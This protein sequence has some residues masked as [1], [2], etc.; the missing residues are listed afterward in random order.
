MENKHNGGD[1]IHT[2]VES[3]HCVLCCELFVLQESINNF[4]HVILTIILYC[5]CGMVCGGGGGMLFLLLFHNQPVL[6]SS[7]KREQERER[8]KRTIPHTCLY[9]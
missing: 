2:H 3:E 9:I 4:H 1:T 5:C 8:D 7:I 6:R